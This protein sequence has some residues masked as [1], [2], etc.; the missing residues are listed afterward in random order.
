MIKSVHI[1]INTQSSLNMK[2]LGTETTENWYSHIPKS[3]CGH[4]DITV[5]WNQ[6]V[7]TDSGKQPRHNN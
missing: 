6:G 1:Y 2:T 7:Q 4:E 5:L 3:V